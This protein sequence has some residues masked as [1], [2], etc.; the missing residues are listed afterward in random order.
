MLP[1]QAV[2][3][4]LVL[5]GWL[6]LVM[7]EEAQSRSGKGSDRPSPALWPQKWA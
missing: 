2:P 6:E 3:V 5:A 4:E 1:C 7:E